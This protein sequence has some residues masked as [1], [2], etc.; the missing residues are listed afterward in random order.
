[1]V[2]LKVILVLVG[3]IMAV[4]AFV[5]LG[6]LILPAAGIVLAFSTGARDK[7]VRRLPAVGRLRTGA[8]G[9]LVG[10]GGLVLWADLLRSC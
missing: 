7:L 1:M 10:L 4:V 9:F 3:L 2:L 5:F 8:L 6:W